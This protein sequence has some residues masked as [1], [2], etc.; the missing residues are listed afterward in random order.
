ML[1]DPKCDERLDRLQEQ[2]RRADAFTPDLLSDVIAQACPRFAGHGPTAKAKVDRLMESAAWTEAT[3]ALVELEL[4]KWK[5]RRL[6][7]E[8]GE[9]LCSLSKQPWLPLGLDE[10]A[11]GTSRAAAFIPADQGAVELEFGWLNVGK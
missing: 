4:P 9:W 7:Y 2:V 6:V 3:L 10:M 8:D 11:D 5:L 1:F